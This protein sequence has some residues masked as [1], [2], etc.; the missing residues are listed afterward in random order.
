MATRR[1]P[2]A[3]AGVERHHHR[4]GHGHHG[5]EGQRRAQAA[6]FCQAEQPAKGARPQA[7]RPDE[8]RRQVIDED[9]NEGDAHDTG[10]RRHLYEGRERVLGVSPVG[11]GIGQEPDRLDPVHEKPDRREH[12]GTQ[13][14][15][16]PGNH[17]CGED[18]QREEDREA[19][20]QEAEND[21]IPAG[22]RSPEIAD[23]L[24]RQEVPQ[25]ARQEGGEIYL[26]G[27]FI[28][29]IDEDRR[30]GDPGE[31]GEGLEEPDVVRRERQEH[32]YRCQEIIVFDAECLYP[33]HVSL[34]PSV[35]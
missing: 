13:P 32:E 18:L 35:L 19:R 24:V 17:L 33:F 10:E 29:D 2:F 27:F 26:P 12:E 16:P 5:D 15:E 7:A 23:P 8:L 14:L 30:Q 21:G 9:D 11:K 3:V 4:A 1:P 28:P 31:E 25:Q 20:H 22:R 34:H 6:R